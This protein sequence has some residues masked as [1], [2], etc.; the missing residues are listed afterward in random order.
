MAAQDDAIFSYRKGKEFVGKTKMTD[1]EIEVVYEN[2]SKDK[3]Y[4]LPTRNC[5]KF[6]Y[7]LIE[8]LTDSNRLT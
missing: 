6:A 4:Y 7:E 3:K 2:W 5:L 1:E 8:I